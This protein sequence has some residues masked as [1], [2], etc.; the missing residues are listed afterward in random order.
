MQDKRL[1][2][3]TIFKVIK[4]QGKRKKE[5]KKTNWFC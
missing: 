3:K 4:N 5:K 1:K 2:W